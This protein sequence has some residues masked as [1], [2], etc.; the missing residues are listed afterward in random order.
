MLPLRDIH[1]RKP[2]QS[3]QNVL[4][5]GGHAMINDAM[6]EAEEILQQEGGL[7]ELEAAAKLFD[8]LR[9]GTH[10]QKNEEALA[11]LRLYHAGTDDDR[12]RMSKEILQ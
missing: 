3:Y 5:I 1:F 4:M 7:E 12:R 10:Y 11:W 8:D 6:L 9:A 2:T